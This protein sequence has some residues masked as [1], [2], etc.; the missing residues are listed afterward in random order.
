MTFAP[1]PKASELPPLQAPIVETPPKNRGG[2]PR[3]D[4]LP[5]GSGPARSPGTGGKSLETQI[6]SLLVM[7]NLFVMATP[8]RSDALDTYEIAALAKSIDQQCKQ[9][10]RFR[11][12]V[13]AALGVGSGGA[14]AGM[15]LM[16][17]ARRVS[18][19]GMVPAE[20]DA[21]LGSM[22]QTTVTRQG[23]EAPV[24]TGTR[25]A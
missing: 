23:T 4:G 12:Y 10:P 19:H 9:S 13:E 11:K 7:M 15:V 18:R 22:I 25:A 14:L 5:P 17:G 8:F 16:I 3:K 2:R 20:I 24:G 1:G 6:G 21:L